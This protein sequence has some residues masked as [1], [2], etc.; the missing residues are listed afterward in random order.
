M[1][2]VALFLVGLF[3]G[4]NR[5][6]PPTGQLA[7]YVDT[8]A[9]LQRPP[10][11]PPRDD[12]A[13][14]LF[15]TVRIDIVDDAGSPA[16]DDCER[17]FALDAGM[18]DAEQSSVG[19]LVPAGRSDLRA[20]VRLFRSVRLHGDSPP[21]DGTIDR[22]FALPSIGTE[23]IVE[24]TALLPL[25]AVGHGPSAEPV[26]SAVSG[27][28]YRHALRD[29]VEPRGCSGTPRGGEAC[30]HGGA[31]WMTSGDHATFEPN[32]TVTVERVVV[33][34]PFFVDVH[35][36]TVGDLRA[37]GLASATDPQ[38]DANCT[39]GDDPDAQDR[40]VDCI[41]WDLAER[42]CESRGG[43]LPT[44]AQ[45][46]FLGSSLSQRRFVW[47]DEEPDCTYAV[48]ARNAEIPDGGQGGGGEGT[49]YTACAALGP[50][51]ERAGRGTRDVLHLP[52]GDV[53]DLIG[54]VSELAHDAYGDLNGSCWGPGLFVDPLCT[55]MGT[56]HVIR[57]GSRRTPGPE[58]AAQ[59]ARFA[60]DFVGR[61]PT[62]YD[63]GFRCA[64]RD[65]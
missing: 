11:E 35:E 55:T 3:A 42:F 65:G 41:G 54:N 46:E 43:S 49:L 53:V 38:R 22:A 30:V 27:R 25:D 39:Y 36:V 29:G 8:D 44:E 26:D 12:V 50:G 34:S 10:G 1:K 2:R 24:V 19:I 64:R 51:P 9:P 5:T 47:G 15:D 57:G 60:T 13:V 16:C 23:G 33:V 58:L 63:V 18:L 45:L 56:A 21:A 32:G 59:V 6:L 14:P 4:C 48:F 37:S 17:A 28:A 40:P 61:T 62:L 7:L 20:R 31:Y 52:G